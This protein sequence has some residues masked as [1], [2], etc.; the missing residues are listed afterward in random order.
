MKN[1]VNYERII[2]NY[3]IAYNKYE[4]IILIIT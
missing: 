2:L 1:K 3:D 4:I